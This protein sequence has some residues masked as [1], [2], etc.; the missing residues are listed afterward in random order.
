[1]NAQAFIPPTPR[2]FQAIS[3][4]YF[5]LGQQRK[6]TRPL[7]RKRRRQCLNQRNAQQCETP[8]QKSTKKYRVPHQIKPKAI[9]PTKKTA[10]P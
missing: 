3:L 9:Q 1:A 10:T 8:P 4:G 7:G 5:S 2:A 6:V